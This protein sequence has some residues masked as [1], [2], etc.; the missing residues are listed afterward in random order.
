MRK[1]MVRVLFIRVAFL[2][3]RLNFEIFLDIYFYVSKVPVYVVFTRK[4]KLML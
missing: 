4:F 1:I 3:K 2:R